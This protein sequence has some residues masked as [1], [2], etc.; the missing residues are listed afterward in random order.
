MVTL[1]GL[2]C[3]ALAT[4]ECKQSFVLVSWILA[5]IAVSTLKP[6]RLNRKARMDMETR[7]FE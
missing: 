6:Q 2:Y 4:T 5:M 7:Y 3:L 1:V